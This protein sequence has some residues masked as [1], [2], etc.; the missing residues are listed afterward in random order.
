[1]KVAV[2]MSGLLRT[3]EITSKNI[4]ENLFKPNDVDLF[5]YA[6][7]QDSN[8]KIEDTIETVND[9]YKDFIVKSKITKF[10]P[11]AELNTM[12]L[13]WWN[14][15]QHSHATEAH[16]K[17]CECDNLRIQYEK[18]NNI[19]YDIVVRL[20]PD[21]ELVGGILN[22]DDLTFDK[23]Q[24]TAYLY[25]GVRNLNMP[26]RNNHHTIRRC[27][28]EGRVLIDNWQK[29]PYFT[30]SVWDGFMIADPETINIANQLKDNYLFSSYTS[31]KCGHYGPKNSK[32]AEAKLLTHLHKNNVTVKTIAHALG[33]EKTFLLRRTLEETWTSGLWDIHPEIIESKKQEIIISKRKFERKR[34]DP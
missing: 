9:I 33:E 23:N 17:C 18:E 29:N 15:P 6:E 27:A 30:S 14:Y 22:I 25:G 32:N 24:K 1:M 20:R 21:F 26:S 31:K 34:D 5:I 19:K 8:R 4:I 7:C 12:G 11:K 10:N 13:E 3:Y 2:C 28:T 16:R